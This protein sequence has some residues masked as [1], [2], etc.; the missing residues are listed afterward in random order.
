MAKKIVL[1]FFL[2]LV[3]C[4]SLAQ[5]RALTNIQ[6][7]KVAREVE[8]T[9]LVLVPPGI[10]GKRYFYINGA[11]IYSYFKDFPDLSVGDKVRVKGEISLA[12]NEK[13][14]KIN[15]KNDIK[16]LGKGDLSPLFFNL[17]E[18]NEAL[19][20]YFIKTKGQIIEITGSK[21][22]ISDDKKELIVY[23][24]NY[25]DI[26]KDLFS[27]GDEIL[28]QGVL[29]QYN[30]RLQLLPRFKKDMEITKK[31][32]KPIQENGFK[33]KSFLELN[34]KNYYLWSVLSSYKIYFIIS[35]LLLF[36]ILI[37]LLKFKK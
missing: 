13:R 28:V 35:S 16:V 32:K 26:N 7:L 22:F 12:H 18:I 34:N 15:S 11:Q 20:G 36:F 4:F 33:N 31:Y 10:L 1:I 30:E 25:V 37:Y 17:N 2:F 5:A 8:V 14:I 24:K 6:D 19:I 3:L 27:A 29:S 23:L 21:V 9:S